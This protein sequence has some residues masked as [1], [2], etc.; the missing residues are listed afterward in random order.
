LEWEG[1]LCG[2]MGRGACVFVNETMCHLTDGL[3]WLHRYFDFVCQCEGHFDGPSCGECKMGWSGPNCDI[4]NDLLVR[5]GTLASPHALPLIIIPSP[6]RM[7][8]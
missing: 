6:V 5:R 1:E 4:Q 2:G 8:Y 7:K 3:F